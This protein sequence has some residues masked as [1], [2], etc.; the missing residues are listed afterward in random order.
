MGLRPDEWLIKRSTSPI[1]HDTAI[2]L[3]EGSQLH[4]ALI[5]GDFRSSICITICMGIDLVF[6]LKRWFPQT[7]L[8]L[9]LHDYWGPCVYEGRLVRASG[10]LCEGG[11]PV[12]CDQCLGGGRRGELAIRSLR[13]QRMFALID[14]LLC[15]SFFLKQRY[16]EWG[17]DPKSISVI[18]NLP[19]LEDSMLLPAQPALRKA[20]VVG[21]FG[22]SLEGPELLI[23]AAFGP[24]SRSSV[25]VGSQRG[26]PAG[27]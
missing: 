24:R 1:T 13:L 12:S 11:D 6:A 9:T 26:G 5:A 18:E 27:G 22:Q 7:K 14:H 25:A 21:F 4:Q 15:P 17:V 16:L 2:D 10:E 8:L 20:L 19:A 3:S 23:D